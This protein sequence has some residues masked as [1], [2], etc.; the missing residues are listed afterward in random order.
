MVRLMG[1]VRRIA[2]ALRRVRVMRLRVRRSDRVPVRVLALPVRIS[3]VPRMRRRRARVRPVPRRRRC[4]LS[5]CV[6]RRRRMRRRVPHRRRMCSIWIFS[7]AI[8]IV[9]RLRRVLRRSNGISRR[10]SRVPERCV[11]ALWCVRIL[12]VRIFSLVLL[13]KFFTK[14]IFALPLK[15]RVMSHHHPAAFTRLARFFTL[16]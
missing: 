4:A 2:L 16:A 14:M 8:W 15:L 5:I 6:V 13:T 1:W 9:V 3:L 7:F 12:P 11:F 10:S